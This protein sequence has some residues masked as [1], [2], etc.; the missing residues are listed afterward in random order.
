MDAVSIRS[1][2]EDEHELL[3]NA[4][5]G[6]MN[7]CGER[8]TR[9]EILTRPEFSH[10]TYCVPSHGD[11]GVVAERAGVPIGVAWALNLPPHDAGYGFIDPHTPEV[12]IWVADKAR[13]QG[14]GRKLL[15]ALVEALAAQ[16]VQRVS[17]SVEAGNTVAK[18]LYRSEGF[19][20]V[21]RRQEDG[22]MVKYLAEG[23]VQ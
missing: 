7:W 19:T 9:D 5:L 20:D 23:S 2:C 8:F 15:R 16:D 4:T 17:L 10:Y 11:T 1:L 3:V 13:G 21:P 18:A 22:V 14:I 6:T 12:S